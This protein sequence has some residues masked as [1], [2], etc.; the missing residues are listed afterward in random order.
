[1]ARGYL[2]ALLATFIFAVASATDLG[3]GKVE[4][5]HITQDELRG[6]LPG[7]ILYFFVLTT[8][9]VLAAL[10]VIGLPVLA[11]LRRIK[12]MTVFWTVGGAILFSLAIGLWTLMSPYNQWCATHLAMC[13][14]KSALGAAYLAVPVVVAF[15]LA[16][17]IPFRRIRDAA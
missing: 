8:P 14:A 9:F 10:T 16:A 5:G 6:L 12:A 1:L 7:Y 15:A 3:F 4:L 2:G 13:G 17:K 11:A